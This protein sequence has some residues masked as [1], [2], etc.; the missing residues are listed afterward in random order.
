M[1]ERIS[2]ID[3]EAS[4]SARVVEVLG[5]G[6]I[7]NRLRALGIRPGVKITKVSA[8]FGRGPA[9]VRVGSAQVALGFSMSY[10]VIVEVER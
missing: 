3:L 5:G 7:H 6:G 10:K 4:E 8:A 2:L 9:V 1:P